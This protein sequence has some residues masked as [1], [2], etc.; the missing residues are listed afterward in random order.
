MF[1]EILL[2]LQKLFLLTWRKCFCQIVGVGWGRFCT[3]KVFPFVLFNTTICVLIHNSSQS[4]TLKVVWNYTP[5]NVWKI[6]LCITHLLLHKNVPTYTPFCELH[7]LAY[8]TPHIYTPFER[9]HTLTC[10]A[11]FNATHLLSR[12]TVWL[13]HTFHTYTSFEKNTLLLAANLLILHTFCT[14]ICFYNTPFI[15]LHTFWLN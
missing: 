5:L 4:Y 9:I 8:Y 1:T 7:T 11:P 6:H 14:N 10:F 2:T 12:Y 13:L 15:Y 3:G